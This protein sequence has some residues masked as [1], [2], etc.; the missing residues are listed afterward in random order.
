VSHTKEE[1]TPEADL[2]LAIEAYGRTV[3]RTMELV[4]MG[5]L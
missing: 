2:R 1:N 5:E 4:A 3:T